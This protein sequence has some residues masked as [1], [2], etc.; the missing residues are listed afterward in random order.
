MWV[1]RKAVPNIWI[2]KCIEWHVEYYINVPWT[3]NQATPVFFFRYISLFLELRRGVCVCVIFFF[4]LNCLL[5]YLRQR[6]NV[7]VFSGEEKNNYFILQLHMPLSIPHSSFTNHHHYTRMHI[8][9]Q[10]KF[11]VNHEHMWMQMNL[12]L[13]LVAL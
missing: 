9:F 4:F 8:S 11:P 1:I 12:L 7:W 10:L 13:V 6:T 2:E 3:R 5:E